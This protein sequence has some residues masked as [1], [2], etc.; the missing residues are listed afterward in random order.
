M[1]SLS[2]DNLIR[3]SYSE[4]AAI[5]LE[6]MYSCRDTDLLDELQNRGIAA[7]EAGFTEWVSLTDPAVSI[8]FCWYLVMGDSG[9]IKIVPEPVRANVMIVSSLG[10]DISNDND[11]ALRSIL[12]TLAWEDCV[13]GATGKKLNS[14]DFL[15]ATFH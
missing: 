8:G 15:A 12:D 10:Y 6:H 3:M 13:R 11:A 2:K 4:L 7:E 9:R 14:K 1:N 5:Q